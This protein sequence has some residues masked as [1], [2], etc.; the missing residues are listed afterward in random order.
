MRL[1]AARAHRGLV[2]VQAAAPMCLEQAHRVA[3]ATLGR[4]VAFITFISIALAGPCAAAKV[5]VGSTLR[6]RERTGGRVRLA[7]ARAQRG[8]VHVQA[9]APPSLVASFGATWH[10]C[11][12]VTVSQS[13]R[14][15]AWSTRTG[16]QVPLLVGP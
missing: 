4:T 2:H 7:A 8:L 14:P 10:V 1:A 6:S 5:A 12:R 15:C 13:V 3:G 16:A 9:A 11:T